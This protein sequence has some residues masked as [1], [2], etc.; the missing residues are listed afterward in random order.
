[1]S[2][3]NFDRE[4]PCKCNNGSTIRDTYCRW[5]TVTLSVEIYEDERNSSKL[6]KIIG[7]RLRSNLDDFLDELDTTKL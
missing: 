2:E 6:S 1:M 4:E 7:A 3:L 5:F